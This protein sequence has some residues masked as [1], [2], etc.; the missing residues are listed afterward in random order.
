MALL[1]AH[2]LT[3]QEFGQ[4]K[5]DIHD[6][7]SWVLLPDG[8]IL[9]VDANNL[10]DLRSTEIFDPQVGR[11]HFAG[12]TPV[13]ISDLDPDGGGSHEVG[14]NVL[15]YDGTVLAVGGNGHNAIYD[16]ASKTW[17][18]APDLP[19]VDG[20]QLDMADGPAAV[21]PNG[22]VLLLASPGVFQTRS[23]LYEWNGT[24]FIDTPRTPDC[25]G[26]TSFQFAMLVLPTG[27]VLMTDYTS[28]VELYT[29][30]HG[31][32]ESGVP[33][34]TGITEPG[35]GVRSGSEDTVL[36]LYP[37]RTYEL[38]GR[39]LAGISQGGYYG[40]D[41]QTST[42]FPL[43]RLTN[44]DTGHVAYLRTHDHSSVAIGSDKDATTQFDVAANVE[45]GSATLEVVTNGIA[46]PPITVDVK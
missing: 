30:A 33:I 17:S 27:E 3:W 35:G 41:V 32:V 26:A 42:N 20:L 22:D 2:S 4:Q 29:P 25:A 38:A 45:A 12:D 24:T 34:I 8:T 10:S 36:E 46:S 7:E 1:D 37:G 23:Y 28:D 40:D 43:V 15:R 18:S 21:L 13:Q 31:V 11:W 5:L 6:E 9:T 14:P 16:L 44:A 19:V 39:R